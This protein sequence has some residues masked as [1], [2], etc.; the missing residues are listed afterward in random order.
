MSSPS[1]QDKVI[2]FV[3]ARMA[4]SR[5][6]G[7]PL[8]PILGRPMIEHVF[9]RAERFKGW[10]GLYLATCDK[11]IA[12]LGVAHGWPV[13][14][15]S[16]KHTR[17][18][19]RIAEAARK[20]GQKLG[21]TDIVVCVQGD[22][23]ML[24]PDMIAAAI[25]PLQKDRQVQGTILAMEIAERGQFENPDTVKII[26]N[27]RDEVLYTS[28]A[29]I[30]YCK[31][32]FSLAHGARRIYGIFAFRWQA[33]QSFTNMTEGRLERLESCDSNRLLDGDIRQRIAPYPFRK[34]FSV[35][36]PADIAQVE[37]HMKSDPLWGTY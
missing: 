2:G 27:K 13:I 12:D 11:P 22:E 31:G 9:R 34:S 24:H 17:C 6:P 10:H 35:D 14:M 29:P 26:Y 5:F 15:T 23:P 8:H 7:K 30:P 3:P 33:L 18:L 25:K 32:K 19:D 4:A 1:R 21:P 36:S 20:C 28:R 37:A 16:D